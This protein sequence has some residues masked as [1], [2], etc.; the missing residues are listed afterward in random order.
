MPKPNPVKDLFPCPVCTA[1]FDESEIYFPV[2]GW[3]SEAVCEACFID[4]CLETRARDEADPLNRETVISGVP[5]QGL[6][7]HLYRYLV[8]QERLV[9]QLGDRIQELERQVSTLHFHSN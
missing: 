1:R 4:W 8:G 2:N 9:E 3:N 6:S 7:L 5:T